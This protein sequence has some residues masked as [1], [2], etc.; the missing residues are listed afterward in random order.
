MKRACVDC[1]QPFTPAKRGQARCPAHQAAHAQARYERRPRG[2]RPDVRRAV[3]E[4]D[5]FTCQGCGHHDPTGR[6][7]HADH[8]VP[9][10]QGG[11]DQLDNL[12]LLCTV[13]CHHARARRAA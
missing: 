5:N 10:A 13:R 1:G 7:L 2:N 12:R 9:Y 6:T 3:L 8:I 11:G 4:R